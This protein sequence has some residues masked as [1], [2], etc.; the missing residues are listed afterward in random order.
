MQKKTKYTVIGAGNG[1][2]A[3]AAHLAIMGFQVALYNRTYDHV[4]MIA[5]RGGIE[6]ES[7]EGCE[8]GFG[9]V[10][11]VTDKL[12]EAIGFADVVMV[13][14]P[15]SGHAEIA[16]KAAPYFHDGQIVLLHPGRTGGAIEFH[17]EVHRSGLSADITIA[18]TETFI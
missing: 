1:G 15:S 16:R 3:M 4:A 11:L 7:Y 8:R 17:N 10:A 6:L 9:K 14:I 13:V 5:R 12:E 2:K 18:E